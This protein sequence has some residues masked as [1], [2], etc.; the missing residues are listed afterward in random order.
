MALSSRQSEPSLP[1]RVDVTSNK[2]TSK[3]VSLLG[4]FLELRYY[5]SIL[6]DSIKAT[7]TFSDTG[8]AIDGQSVIE[9]LPLVG[10]EDVQLRFT[11]LNDNEIKVDLNINKVTPVAADSNKTLVSI[12]LVSEEFIKNEEGRMRLTERYSGKIS[13]HVTSIIKGAPPAQEEPK[14]KISLKTKK[15]VDIEETGNT[16][17][18]LGNSRKPFYILNIFLSILFQLIR[19]LMFPLKIIQQVEEQIKLQDF[20]SLKLQKGFILNL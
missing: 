1:S 5:E 3:T 2:D 6:Q 7:Y 17:N 4:G 13:D 12:Q 9:G 16:Y 14:T 8:N 11:D 15:E 18:F 19:V 10:T 20:F